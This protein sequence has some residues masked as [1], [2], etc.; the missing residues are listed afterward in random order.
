MA[1]IAIKVERGDYVQFKAVDGDE[2]VS[3]KNIKIDR[4]K[5]YSE[6]MTRINREFRD[7]EKWVDRKFIKI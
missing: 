4:S 3:Q 2:I 7:F 5:R 6:E 1:V